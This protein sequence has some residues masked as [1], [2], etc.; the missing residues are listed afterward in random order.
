VRRAILA[1]VPGAA[2][3]LA[4]CGS[5]AASTPAA[6]AH[7]GFAP[8][9]AL[10]QRAAVIADGSH[11]TGPLAASAT[12][13]G[14]VVLRSRD[15]S[16]LTGF[17]ARVTDPHSP[18]FGHYLR[19]GAFAGRFGPTIAARRAV[20]AALRHDGLRVGPA[21]SSGLLVPFTGTAAQ[22]EHAFATHLATVRTAGGATRRT[23]TSA[24]TLPASVAQDVT[25]VVG[26]D[27]HTRLHSALS[28]HHST[29]AR[30][31]TAPARTAT[32]AGGPHACPAATAAAQKF[33][34]LTDDQI[35][36]AYGA[37]GLYDAG[38]TGAGQHIA[39][40]ELE[41]FSKADILH[42]DTCY[43]GVVRAKQMLA[44]V[45]LRPVLGG[46]PQG[47]GTGEATLDV[48]DLEALA[49]GASIDVYV[50]PNT[51]GAGQFNA[52]AEYEAIADSDRDSIVS[53]SWGICEQ[54]LQRGQPGL[55]QAENL[56]F[57]QAAAQ[58]QTV[59]AAAGDN[60]SD[61]CEHA[62]ITPQG[63]QNALSVDD[64]S[65]QP[66]VV[67]VGGTTIDAATP[68][69][70]LQHVWNDGAAVGGGG[71]GISMSW[72]MPAWQAASRVPGIARPGSSDYR[73]AAR[74]ENKLGDPVGFCHAHVTGATSSTPCRLV[75]DV[76]AQADDFTGAITVYST[77]F[78]AKESENGWIT[79][80]GTSSATPIWAASLALVDASPA[81]QADGRAGSGSRARGVGFVAPLLYGIASDPAAYKASFTDVRTGNNDI[82][83]IGNG[84][85]YPAGRGYDVTTGLG[86][87]RLTD[88]GGTSGLAT[89]LCD[90]GRRP[91]TPTV[92][93]LS[94]RSGSTAGGERLTITGSG[95]AAGGHSRVSSVQVGSWRV[96]GAAITVAG[97]HTL[98]VV[99]PP[100]A[101]TVPPGATN[102]QTGAGRVRILVALRDGA[103]STISAR[104]TF[105]YVSAHPDAGTPTVGT[106]LPTGGPAD[107]THTVLILGS[108]FHAGDRVT[109]GGV[110]ARTSRVVSADR[111]RVLAPPRSR[112]THCVALPHHGVYRHENARNDVCQVAVR[113][114]SASGRVS[115]K[116]TI[117][118]PVEGAVVFDALGDITK[119]AR[120]HC[121]VAPA[122]DEYDYFPQPKVTSISTSFGPSA[123]AD[124]HGGTVVTVTGRGLDPLALEWADIGN[125]HRFTSEDYRYLF[126]TGTI[127]QL[128]LRHVKITAQIK[129]LPFSVRTLAGQSDAITAR[130]AGIPKITSVVNTTDSRN[131]NGL[132]GGPSTGRTPL[133]ITGTGMRGQVLALQYSGDRKGFSIGTQYTFHVHGDTTLT[134]Q[135]V[136]QNPAIV[137]V[138]PCT[139]TGCTKRS[140]ASEFWL[141][142]PGDPSVAS[143]TPNAG[144]TAGGD[145]VTVTGANLGCPISVD[146][147]AIPSAT[148][149]R[150]RALLECGSSTT[151]TAVAPA[152]A[153]GTTVPVTVTTAESYFTGHTGT[154]RATFS[155]R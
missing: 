74:V 61:D 151:L 13:H 89:Y 143:A 123:L 10:V 87:P 29:A 124:E 140:L 114:T 131:L 145:A 31:A 104:S 107:R 35:A 7:H 149:T 37:T 47:S 73:A 80:G 96:R 141:Y 119:G 51:S 121:E 81:C 1:V 144:S 136:A 11:V 99:L 40:Y 70:P 33:G 112:F 44:R 38:D 71:G 78:K 132:Y 41:P 25:A 153:A 4:L 3:V 90:A 18:S 85:V 53:T 113:V 75:P 63:G 9:R 48:E 134:T 16:A 105:T 64:P 5:V 133:K 111:I 15:E 142:P 100:A 155:Y 8:R 21:T 39:L 91:A 60:G 24:V 36:S 19:R 59:F 55:Q 68:T 76:S 62:S 152:E 46:Q 122:A 126:A 66:Y 95:F 138:E 52:L 43:F 42:F 83:G 106:A 50:G 86:S 102:G 56:I 65:S 30:K 127:L 125:P 58:G 154:S 98:H 139:V 148:V 77:T 93:R 72:Q 67:G 130:Y 118:P 82:Y 20:T 120:C 34:G 28:I 17:I 129:K 88:A 108:G 110:Q 117:E 32:A 45:H 79:I 84:T 103:S 49:P 6:A 92:T 97:P 137:A 109:F 12:V 128:K 94:P 23:T 22:A 101:R 14:T 147:G 69:D 135:T 26:L 57:Q 2:A 146:F 150:G 27:G 54:A 115:P 116:T